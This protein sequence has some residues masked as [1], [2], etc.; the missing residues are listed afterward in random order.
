MT[1]QTLETALELFKKE[2][3][4]LDKPACFWQYAD[5]AKVEEGIKELEQLK[6]E[7]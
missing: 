5:L 6:S 2:R 3:I 1:K 7:L 4:K